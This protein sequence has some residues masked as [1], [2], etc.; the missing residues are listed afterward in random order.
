[1]PFNLSIFLSLPVCRRSRK[2]EEGVGRGWARS[3]I[4]RP[5]ESLAL[6]I[7]NSILSG[8]IRQRHIFL[9][10]TDVSQMPEAT[11]E[12]RQDGIEGAFNLSER[13]EDRLKIQTG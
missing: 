5:R 8:L 4:I 3:R 9:S 6:W 1:M 10:A 11:I 12:R 2:R 7:N 13:D